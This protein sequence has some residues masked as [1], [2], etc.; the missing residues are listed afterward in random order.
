MFVEHAN[1]VIH[2]KCFLT[3]TDFKKIHFFNINVIYSF[4]FVSLFKDFIML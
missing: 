4:L 1:K 3:G 2:V